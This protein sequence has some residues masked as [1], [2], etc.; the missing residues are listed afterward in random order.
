MHYLNFTG[1]PQRK[2]RGHAGAVNCVCLNEDST[3]AVSG[4]IDATVKCWDAR[5]KS[6]DPIQTLE[7]MKDSVTCLIVTDHEIIVGCADGKVR[8]YDLRNGRLVT[9][10][11]TFDTTS[12]VAS[13]SLTSDG[14]CYVVNTTQ[15][16]DE[17]LKLMDKTNGSMLQEYF[18]GCDNKKGY[19]I[20]AVIGHESKQVLVGSDKGDVILFDLVKGT[21]LES[22]TVSQDVVPSISF[23]PSK[24]EF[25]CASKHQIFVFE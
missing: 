23:H 21:K 12:A 20:E 7:E 1:V 24:E 14:Q 17:S 11:I 16:V 2:W 5:S 13:I 25:V 3:V 22:F 19:K 8:T 4:S 18:T 9:D 10:L 6:L 15:V